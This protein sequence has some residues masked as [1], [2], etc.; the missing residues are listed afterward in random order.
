MASYSPYDIRSGSI[1]AIWSNDSLHLIRLSHWLYENDLRIYDDVSLV[2]YGNH[3][4]MSEYGL[5]ITSVEVPA[6][7]MGRSA[8]DE[9]SQALIEGRAFSDVILDV[10]LE[11]RNTVRVL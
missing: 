1:T 6:A 2:G 3:P 8:I 10:R 9:I 11:K 4:I 7:Q 5:P